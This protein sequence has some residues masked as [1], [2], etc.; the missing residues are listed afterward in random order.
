MSV[1]QCSKASHEIWAR[2]CTIATCLQVTVFHFHA[3]P[4]WTRTI[5][6]RLVPAVSALLFAWWWV[7]I[8]RLVVVFIIDTTAGQFIAAELPC[9][10]YV[11]LSTVTEGCFEIR[12]WLAFL[13]TCSGQIQKC[14]LGTFS[15]NEGDW[16]PSGMQSA[17]LYF[18]FLTYSVCKN[19]VF[20]M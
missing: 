4:W 8:Q 16:A 5:I 3:S 17:V 7:A 13:S 1:G 18:F 11:V 15:A 6:G 2:C 19:F 12:K 14:I 20:W 10:M 9:V